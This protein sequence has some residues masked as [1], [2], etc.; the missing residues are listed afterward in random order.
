MLLRHV[1]ERRVNTVSQ[2]QL[3][4][5]SAHSLLSIPLVN[6][7]CGGRLKNSKNPRPDLHSNQVTP[8]VRKW[9]H[10]LYSEAHALSH[11]FHYYKVA[12]TETQN[13]RC[14]QTLPFTPLS[15]YF[16]VS[17]KH[18]HADQV[19]VTGSRRHCTASLSFSRC[20]CFFISH[21]WSCLCSI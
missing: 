3:A 2:Y 13:T 16:S 9:L 12:H 7:P 14:A 1:H 18:T 19:W 5:H 15:H 11:T 17:H 6:N 10:F 20:L 4:Q 8:P 21:S